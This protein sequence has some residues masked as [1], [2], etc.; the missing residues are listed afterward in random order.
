[1]PHLKTNSKGILADGQLE[2]KEGFC[3][4]DLAEGTTLEIETQ[5][6]NYKLVK[7]ADTHVRISGHPTFCPQPVEVEI[8]GAFGGSPVVAPN[9]RFIGPGMRLIFKHPVLGSITTSPI[10]GIH[11]LS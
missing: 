11:R 7:R 2:G 9:P 1:M 4:D 6:R 10:L 3:I 5:H 8:E